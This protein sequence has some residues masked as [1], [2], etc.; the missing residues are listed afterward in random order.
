MDVPRWVSSQPILHPISVI[1]C[2]KCQGRKRHSTLSGPEFPLGSANERCNQEID[3]LP[4]NLHMPC[5]NRA[6]PPH[7]TV[8]ANHT[9]LQMG[10][11]RILPPIEVLTEPPSG[12]P[13]GDL[14]GRGPERLCGAWKGLCS[15]SHPELIFH[16]VSAPCWLCDCRQVEPISSSIM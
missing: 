5:A 2:P 3:P 15:W 16:P 14:G 7:P 11:L 12:V 6:S 1:R 9:T 13:H 4:G 10:K 8:W